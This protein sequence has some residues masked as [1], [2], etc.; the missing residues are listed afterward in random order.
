M[1][2]INRH[3]ST[4]K[5]FYVI[6]IHLPSHI[7]H[8]VPYHTTYIQTASTAIAVLAVCMCSVFYSVIIQLFRIF[9]VSIFSC[10]VS[11]VV[12]QEQEIL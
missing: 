5:E 12:L 2:N 9:E 10:L 11:H 6:N 1:Q 8:N 4:V 3:L 7:Q